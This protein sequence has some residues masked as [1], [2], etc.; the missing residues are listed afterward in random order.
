[1]SDVSADIIVVGCGIAGASVAAELSRTHRVLILEREA[2][3]AYHSTGRSAALF[4]ETYGNSIVRHLS[5]ASRPFFVSPPAEFGPYPL[6]RRRGTLH[7]ARADQI[8]NLI[9]FGTALEAPEAVRRI[10][11]ELARALCPILRPETAAQAIYEPGS[12]DVDVHAL[13]QAY[14][15]IFRRNGGI[16]ITDAEVTALARRDGKWRVSTRAGIADASLI[17]NA[18]GAWADEIAALAGARPCSVTPCRR[19]AF[20]VEVPPDMDIEAWPLTIDLAETFYIKPDAGLLL[21]SPADESPMPPCDVQPDEI[22]IAVAVDRVEQATTLKI[23]RIRRR[24]AGLRSFAP[25]RAPVIGFDPNLTGF[26]WLAGQ[27]GYGIQTA[28]ACATLAAAL[29]RDD[30]LPDELVRFDRLS[31]TPARFHRA[32]ISASAE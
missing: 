32:R 18:A 24:W 11:G 21:V 16:L 4:S 12:A 27:G 19:T 30:A 17:I 28:P 15:R 14:L 6:L 20:T 13:H 1:V 8:A 26:F 3:P 7:V 25:D 2:Q 9:A 29:V 5:R 31:V 22:D 23:K 10:D